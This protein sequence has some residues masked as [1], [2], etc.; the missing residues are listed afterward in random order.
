M[1]ANKTKKNLNIVR[2]FPKLKKVTNKNKKYHYKLDSPAKMREKAI[3][4]GIMYEYNNMGKTKKQ[5]ATAKKGRF[6]ILRIYRRNKKLD[7]CRKITRDMRYIDKKY[8]LGKTTDICGKKGTP[9]MKGGQPSDEDIPTANMVNNVDGET[10]GEGDVFHDN[11][12]DPHQPSV[13]IESTG[14][15]GT[16]FVE[17]D[18][19]TY[20]DN[21]HLCGKSLERPYPLQYLRNN[22]I[23]GNVPDPEMRLNG[24]RHWRASAVIKLGCRHFFHYG[25]LDNYFKR[26]RYTPRNTPIRYVTAVDHNIYVPRTLFSHESDMINCP[27]C[28]DDGQDNRCLTTNDELIVD[29]FIGNETR[30]SSLGVQDSLG[31]DV[32]ASENYQNERYLGR[33]IVIDNNNGNGCLPGSNCVISG[34]KGKKT[35]KKGKETKKKGKKT[36]KTKKTKRKQKGGSNTEVQTVSIVEEPSS[37]TSMLP[38]A[39]LVTSNSLVLP[40]NAD[41]ILAYGNKVRESPPGCAGTTEPFIARDRVPV[42]YYTPKCGLCQ[43]P[44]LEPFPLQLLRENASL[45]PPD[46]TMMENG[47]R[48]WRS[49]AIFQVGCSGNHRF[50]FGCLHYYL[51]RSS[52]ARHLN[53][54]VG[55]YNCPVCEEPCIS[56]S[57]SHLIK[58]FIGY[59]TPTSVLGDSWPRS[60]F[61]IDEV[62]NTAIENNEEQRI[63]DATYWFGKPKYL[64]EGMP[65][66]EEDGGNSC[67]PGESCVISGGKGKTIKGKKIR[68]H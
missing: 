56:W 52:Y 27:K 39:N 17:K 62:D 47:W 59:E 24:W 16:M 12:T 26:N 42:E 57:D 8:K 34:G 1:G 30:I 48:H 35:K 51:T 55:P 19:T 29:T 41:L 64:G 63:I 4:E 67:L 33:N 28:I 2:S 31:N 44:L 65:T 68:K 49:N 36:K 38:N 53:T 9:K 58:S 11:N 13:L 21:C 46:G 22:L 40:N 20:L 60:Y 37:D 5:A 43:Q 23:N 50:H 7:E 10:P 14:R 66:Q 15:I 18:A 54:S 25:C 3:D 45:S 61:S 32:N 6:N